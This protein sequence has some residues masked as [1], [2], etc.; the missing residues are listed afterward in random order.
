MEIKTK[1]RGNL[2]ADLDKIVAAAGESALRATGVAGARVFQAE[3]KRLVPK[4]TRTIE[5]NIII[6][7]AEEKSDSN[8]RQTYLVTVR[9]GKE[10]VEGDAFY[11]RFVEEGH[12]IVLRKPKET[13]WKAHRAA[14][15]L[16]FGT[17][18][19]AARPFIRPAFEGMK[20]RALDAMRERLREKLKESLGGSK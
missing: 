13:S 14:M 10:N 19:V 8:K 7:R 5:R 17:S 18:R 12:K 9:T 3:A 6:K 11:W 1:L 2:A 16:E 15:E 4:D 20:K